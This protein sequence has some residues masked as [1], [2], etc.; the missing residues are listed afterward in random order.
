[1]SI[2]PPNCVGAF[3]LQISWRNIARLHGIMKFPIPEHLKEN[4]VFQQNQNFNA[5]NQENI[6]DTLTPKYLILETCGLS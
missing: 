2:L 3:P 1:M 6:N 4:C 5:Y